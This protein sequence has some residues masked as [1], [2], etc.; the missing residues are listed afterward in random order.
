MHIIVFV[1][2]KI[3]AD[4]VLVLAEKYVEIYWR[5]L[6][7]GVCICSTFRNIEKQNFILSDGLYSL[8]SI[9]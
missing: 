1:L 3:T 5:I 2:Y 8:L 4:K 7:S 6:D 9:Q